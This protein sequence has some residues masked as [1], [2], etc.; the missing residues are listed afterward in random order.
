MSRF[1]APSQPS[2]ATRPEATSM[3]CRTL[4]G[5]PLGVALGMELSTVGRSSYHIRDQ[6][7]TS[8]LFRGHGS[9]LHFWQH[10]N[11]FPGLPPRCEE[12]AIA[13][14]REARIGWFS[15]WRGQ[16]NP[17]SAGW[18][19]PEASA[20][21]RPAKTQF[22]VALHMCVRGRLRGAASNLPVSRT[23][24]FRTRSRFQLFHS[25]AAA[26]HS[27]AIALRIRAAI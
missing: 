12:W 2:G 6:R 11:R 17:N 4:Y 9:P 21:G 14:F 3:L 5:D 15:S 23:P 7:A 22:R 18:G 16:Y 10:V 13:N 8:S 25:R 1:P 20:S 24:E 19:S 27:S 26:A